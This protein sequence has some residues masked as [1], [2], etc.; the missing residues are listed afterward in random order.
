MPWCFSWRRSCRC[1]SSG[2]RPSSSTFSLALYALF[3]W[4]YKEVA[5]DRLIARGSTFLLGAASDYARGGARRRADL[6]EA[7]ARAAVL[8]DDRARRRTPPVAARYRD[9]DRVHGRGGRSFPPTPRSPA[10]STTRAAIARPSTA[11]TGFPVRE[12]SRDLREHRAR[13]RTRRGDGRRRARERALAHRVP[14]QPRLFRRRPFERAGA[15]LLPRRPQRAAVPPPRAA[16]ALAVARRRDDRRLGAGDD[17]RVAVHVFGR[18]RAGRQ[19][20]FPELLSAVSAAD[21]AAGG[22]RAARRSRSRSARCSP[23][24]SSSIRF[25]RRSIPASTSSRDRCAGCRSS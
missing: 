21:A 16:P 3:L 22:P 14:S 23:R 19:S 7:D 6:L 10:S 1:T 12:R 17:P 4:C 5:A 18:R 13:A 20:L 11:R 15:V 25:T 8:P 24:R 9:G 2:S